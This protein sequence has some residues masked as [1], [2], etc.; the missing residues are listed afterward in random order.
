MRIAAGQDQTAFD[1]ETKKDIAGQMGRKDPHLLTADR[2]QIA[3]EV[4]NKLDVPAAK[5]RE[6]ADFQFKYLAQVMK[7]ASRPSGS[8]TSGFSRRRMGVRKP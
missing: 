3:E 6:A 4:A 5:V 1:A 8:L 2:D 7:E